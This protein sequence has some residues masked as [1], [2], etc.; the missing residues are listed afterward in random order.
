M[1]ATDDEALDLVV[2]SLEVD[3][4]HQRMD[5]TLSKT[6]CVDSRAFCVFLRVCSVLTHSALSAA[7]GAH[8]PLMV[9]LVEMA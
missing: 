2:G 5:P 3:G 9:T 1:T 6:L 8:S 7:D 4:V